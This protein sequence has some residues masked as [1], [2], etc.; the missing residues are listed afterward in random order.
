MMMMMM[1]TMQGVGKGKGHFMGLF[2]T[3]AIRPT[4]F[5]PA[6]I[7]CIHLQRHN[8]SYR[9]A[10]PLQAKAGTI[11]NEFCSVIHERTRFFYMP[12]SWDMGHIILLPLRRK[13]Y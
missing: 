5:L 2:N 12:Q 4:V 11:T 3:V 10:R 8:A 9:C 6:T 13:A 1:M 7:S